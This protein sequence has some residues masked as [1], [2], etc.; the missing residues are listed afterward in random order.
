MKKSAVG[1][2]HWTFASLEPNHFLQ[3]VR[4]ATKKAGGSTRNGRDS[5]GKRLGVKKLG[6]MRVIPGNIIIRQ[7]GKTYHNGTNT[8][9]GRD[10]TIYAVSNGY[11]HFFYDKRKKHQIVSVTP[12]NVY[13]KPQSKPIV[14]LEAAME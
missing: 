8:K 6:G 3:T 4:F 5:I 9:L 10:F 14:A 2:T 1:N 13:L 11:V 12:T 7:R